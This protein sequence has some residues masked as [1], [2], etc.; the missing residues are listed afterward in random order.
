MQKR[1]YSIFI[2]VFLCVIGI[3][4]SMFFP[5]VADGYTIILF[6][7]L[8]AAILLTLYLLC[9]VEISDKTYLFMTAALIFLVFL[10]QLRDLK[11]GLFMQKTGDHEAVMTGVKELV[12]FGHFTE[13]VWYYQMHHHQLFTTLFYAVLNRLFI[14]MGIEGPVSHT[15]TYIANALL[16]DAG[17]LLFFFGIRRIANSRT[18][19][20]T[21]L[22]FAL[23]L[24]YYGAVRRVYPHQLSVVFA[25][26]AI[27]I[28]CRLVSEERRIRRVILTILFGCA[29]ALAM[30]VTGI[31]AI[32]LPAVFIYILICGKRMRQ[33]L[34]ELAGLLIG[35]VLT[36]AIISGVYSA[37]GVL[38]KANAKNMRL[39][40]THWIAM[41]LSENGV[42][43]ED[44]FQAMINADT[45]DAK[46]AY[47]ITAI[48]ERLLSRGFFES[49][50]FFYGKEKVIWIGGHYGGFK[51]LSLS[52]SK[53]NVA[54]RLLLMT[55]IFASVLKLLLFGGRDK[56]DV[57]TAVYIWIFGIFLFFLIWEISPTYLF[58][59]FPILLFASSRFLVDAEQFMLNSNTKHGARPSGGAE[60][61]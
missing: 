51:I 37:L 4:L 26:V 10:L 52:T 33:T 8:S 12:L 9:R 36:T 29:A 34:T 40:Y 53:Y 48:K 15:A 5:S 32:A 21:S 17:I 57:F 56:R 30:S 49:L 60:P 25:C 35:F 58:S 59:S 47:A 19:F 41:G 42:Y 23:N 1:L 45:K 11:K 46:S 13:S 54:Y 38:D 39:P 18:A 31:F 20:L 24:G 2:I 14:Y 50:R 22:L 3:I 61:R 28:L 16:T 44:D 6:F 7:S 43:L 27:F 55:M